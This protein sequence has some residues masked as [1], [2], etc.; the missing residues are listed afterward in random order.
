E[1]LEAT[2]AQT[3]LSGCPLDLQRWFPV[4]GQ[5]VELPAYPWQRQTLIHPVT[6]E[7]HGLL[8]RHYCHPLLGYP[9]VQQQLTWENQLDTARYPWLADH[10]VGEGVV[11]PGAGYIELALAAIAQQQAESEL[12]ELEALEIHAP[13]LLSDAPS[14]VV[15][16]AI[17]P[18]DGALSITARPHTSDDNWTAHVSARLLE[19]PTGLA[20]QRRLSS[21]PNRAPDFDRAQHAELTKMIG[22]GYGPAFSTIAHGWIEAEAAIGEF[23]L[24]TQLAIDS[25]GYLLHPGLLDS[26]FQ[27]AFPLLQHRVDHAQ[28]AHKDLAYV[29]TR[30][31][32]ILVRRGGGLPRYATAQVLR[33]APHSLTAVFA[34]YDAEGQCV[35]LA[36]QARFKAIRLRKGAAQQMDYL[37]YQLTPVPRNGLQDTVGLVWDRVGVSLERIQQVGQADPQLARYSA[38]LEPL[39]DAHQGAVLR[40]LMTALADPQGR[41]DATRLE[42]LREQAGE[43]QALLAFCLAQAESHGVLHGIDGGWQLSD[44]PETIAPELVWNALLQDYPDYFALVLL[45]GRVGQR[46]PALLQGEIEAATLR[47]GPQRYP[48][49][50]NAIVGEAGTQLLSGQLAGL[51]NELLTLL[52]SGQRLRLLETG[53]AAP[54]L[55]ERLAPLLNLQRCDLSFAS[56]SDSAHNAA[57]TLQ[58]RFPLLGIKD[59]SQPAQDQHLGLV[60]L[61]CCSLDAA[62]ALLRGTSA[63]LV[64]GAPA[65]L[66]G[67]Q[68]AGWLDGALG[69]APEWWQSLPN[70]TPLSSHLGQE[71]WEQM[72]QEVGFSNVRAFP[73]GGAY[74]LL[75]QAPTDALV[76]RPVAATLS[77]PATTAGWL[78]VSA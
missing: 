74:L 59:F 48:E 5:R 51:V 76:H 29:P 66:V 77:E 26:A 28:S 73:F 62:R 65:I 43:Q 50:F 4:A 72:L 36:D 31:E 78:L 38:E 60:A 58:Q 49:L 14:K 16:V 32:R 63:Q 45:A 54:W 44:D 71:Q 2:L 6:R 35:A 68:G 24:P 55:V 19:Q 61:N 11:F 47:S 53:C 3:L 20:L 30:I 75:A 22:L 46:L 13:L 56:Q 39:L 37:D 70:Q 7:S 23:D 40:Q 15:R 69:V 27:L 64:P 33:H 17:D 18:A 41:L 57:Q 1:Q 9:L 21:L 12:L 10:K 67:C 42:V 52:P 25:R 8:Q 34:L